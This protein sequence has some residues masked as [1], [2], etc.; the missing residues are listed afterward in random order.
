MALSLKSLFTKIEKILFLIKLSKSNIFENYLYK[1]NYNFDKLIRFCKGKKIALVG[2]SRKLL[3][4][5]ND[6]DSYDVVIRIN[7]IPLEEYHESIGKRCDILMLSNGA[8]NLLNATLPKVY[9]TNK[10]RHITKYAKGDLYHFPIL[11]WK[12]LFNILSARPTSGAMA[13]YLLIKILKDPNITLFGF[14]HDTKTW[15]SSIAPKNLPHNYKNEKK[16][17]AS[18][19]NKKIKY[20][21]T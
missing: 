3:K 2:N 21:K 6:I 11:W 10:N 17:F 19:L 15:Y 13:F 20:A 18:L 16:L 1:E 7:I 14:D 4:E 9:L 5:K 12:E 8:T